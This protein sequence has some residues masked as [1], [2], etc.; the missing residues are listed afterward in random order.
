MSRSQ[1]QVTRPLEEHLFTQSED[2]FH[3]AVCRKGRA[4]HVHDGFIPNQDPPRIQWDI[5]ARYTRHPYFMPNIRL[6]A[7][8][9][10]ML[11]GR[12]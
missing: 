5:H 8:E 12:R 11:D 7:M 1:Y 3:C 6:N 4:S 2:D 10:A 9:Q